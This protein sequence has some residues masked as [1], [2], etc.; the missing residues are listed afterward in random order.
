MGWD[1][2]I[3]ITSSIIDVVDEILRKNTGSAG[4]PFY[5]RLGLRRRIRFLGILVFRYRTSGEFPEPEDKE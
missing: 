4:R 3:K 5:A 2:P 1:S